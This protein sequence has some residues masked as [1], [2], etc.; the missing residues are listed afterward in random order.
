MSPLEPH[1]ERTPMRRR[2]TEVETFRRLLALAFALGGLARGGP[3]AAAEAPPP[4]PS[5]ESCGP[6]YDPAALTAATEAVR[7]ASAGGRLPVVVLDIDGTLLDPSPRM[8]RIFLDA[9]RSPRAPRHAAEVAGRADALDGRRYPYSPESALDR[10]GATE[11][12]TRAY[13]LDA[14]RFAFLSGLYLRED[15]VIEGAA[16]HVRALWEAGAL[17]VYLSGRIAEDMLDG[18]VSVLRAAAFP[19]GIPRTMVVLKPRSEAQADRAW[20]VAQA[21]WLRHLGATVAIYENEPA[22]LNALAAALEPPLAIFVDSKYA[23]AIPLVRGARCIADF[24][25]R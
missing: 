9:L 7:R 25:G 10:I 2:V 19:V 4:K 23:Q 15:V 11:P 13:L 3:A 16:A 14:W 17:V 21:P 12:E 22:N 24:T 20:K 1:A 6:R 5:L 18:T 8:R